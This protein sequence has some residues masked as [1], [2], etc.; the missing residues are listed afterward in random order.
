[1]KHE[2]IY[3]YMRRF[4]IPTLIMHYWQM[5]IYSLL[6]FFAAALPL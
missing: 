1:L 6:G 3:R 4:A 2:E 5:M